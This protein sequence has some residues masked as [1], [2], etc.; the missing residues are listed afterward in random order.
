MLNNPRKEFTNRFK[1]NPNVKIIELLNER[2]LLLIYNFLL[3]DNIRLQRDILP[4]LN[5]NNYQ[6]KILNLKTTTKDEIVK[7]V[8]EGNLIMDDYQEKNYYSLNLNKIPT[9]QVSES[10]ID[11]TI[12]GPKDALIESIDTNLSLIQKRLKSEDLII[13]NKLKKGDTLKLS[14]FDNKLFIDVE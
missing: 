9:R 11:I 8:L 5:Y 10:S 7:E 4:L 3:I 12:S 14:I 2:K 1:N 6:E 13:E